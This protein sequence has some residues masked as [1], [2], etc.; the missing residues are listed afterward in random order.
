MYKF[1]CPTKEDFDQLTR[2]A[3]IEILSAKRCD[4]GSKVASELCSI[5]TQLKMFTFFG[6]NLPFFTSP[7]SQ[8]DISMKKILLKQ[9]REQIQRISLKNKIEK[10]KKEVFLYLK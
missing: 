1:D 4:D 9:L 7:L 3:K 6:P 5:E 10:N 8:D 2:N